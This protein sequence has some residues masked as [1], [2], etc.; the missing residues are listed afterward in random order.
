MVLKYR[1]KEI[2]SPNDIQNPT[3]KDLREILRCHSE[4]TGGMK[5]DLVLIV[6]ALLMRDVR[7]SSAN[8][9]GNEDNSPQDQSDFKYEATIRIS[10]LGWSRDLRHLPEMNSLQLYN[11][12]V[13]STRKYRNI[14]FKG[15]HYK[16]LKCYQFFFEGNMK[17]LESKVFENKAYVRA[18]ALP[19][20]KKTPY[21][22]V[23][24]LAP[25]CDVLRSAC[26]CP[27]GLGLQGKGKCNHI[28]GGL[29][30]IEDFTRRELHKNPEPLTCTSRLYCRSGLC[31]EI[32]V[33]PRNHLT[34]SL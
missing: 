26:T 22:V 16:K 3:A 11:Y 23:V 34:K 10:P 24:E 2:S 8:N 29:F 12:L 9:T 4:S 27:A 19:S 17:K 6:Y 28:R 20:M 21:R 18:T 30:A 14:V 31:H 15:T 13:V 1:D 5:A 7:P 32:R 25:T 33:L